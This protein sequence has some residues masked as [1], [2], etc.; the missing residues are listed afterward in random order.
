MAVTYGAPSVLNFRVYGHKAK[1]DRVFMLELYLRLYTTSGGTCDSFRKKKERK[2]LSFSR[3][4]E[5]R[6]NGIFARLSFNA[7]SAGIIHMCHGT[8]NV[9]PSM[10]ARLPVGLVISE[11]A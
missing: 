1:S 3:H 5:E 6:R 8:K 2:E 9:S 4:G 7:A 10:Y 11:S